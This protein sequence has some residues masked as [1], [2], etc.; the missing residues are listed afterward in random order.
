MHWCRPTSTS[1]FNL[2]LHTRRFDTGSVVC[3]SCANRAGRSTASRR[4]ST[5]RRLS[6][7]SS[8]C[9]V[10]RGRSNYRNSRLLLASWTNSFVGRIQVIQV[11]LRRASCALR[12]RSLTLFRP[13]SFR[14][15]SLTQVPRRGAQLQQRSRT[16]LANLSNKNT[17]GCSQTKEL[18]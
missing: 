12:T 10:G 11:S 3:T 16:L 17:R 5:A 8:P 4:R 9:A 14:D 1:L 15:R 18:R 13:H 6:S 7:P 2:S